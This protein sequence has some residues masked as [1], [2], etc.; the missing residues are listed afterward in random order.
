M[1][2]FLKEMARTSRERANAAQSR[3]PLA[4]LRARALDTAPPLPLRNGTA[5]ELIAEYKRRSPS[6]GPF[7][8]KGTHPCRRVE[9]YAR[10]G[11]AAVS[12]L[13]EP[14]QFDGRLEQLAECAALLAP[15]GVPVMRKDFLVDPYQVC[16][17]RAAG[18][19]G[20]LL[21]M[22]ILSDALLGEM[23]DC[24]REMGLFVLLELFDSADIARAAKACRPSATGEAPLLVGLNCRDLETLETVPAR[25]A[26]LAS[27][28]PRGCTRV[29][30]SGLGTPEDC[31]GAARAG[32]GMALVGGALM[33]ATDPESVVRDM[34]EA[35]RAA[36]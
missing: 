36:A 7:V 18:A 6:R 22:R 28:L 31:A 3:E 30:E 25:L 34:L 2:D 13:T 10:G 1:K 24:A 29:A 14:T 16:E 33:S 17:A 19:G 9:A 5:F 23:Q 32:Y 11:A 35:G 26:E 15:Q 8:S 20:V 12:V 27:R 4:A 21:I